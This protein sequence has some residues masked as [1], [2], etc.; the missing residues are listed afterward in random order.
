M[1]DL[2]FKKLLAFLFIASFLLSFCRP[3]ELVT[4]DILTGSDFSRTGEIKK[5]GLTYRFQQK[6]HEHVKDLFNYIYFQG[7]TL[8]FSLS[9]NRE[10]GKEH[11]KAWFVNSISGEQYKAERLEV[12]GKKIFGFSLLG[13]ILEQFFK[14]EL[15]KPVP[16][17]SYCCKDIPFGIIVEINDR[18]RIIQKEIKNSFV[19][20]YK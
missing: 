13:S 16:G 6:K 14:K 17:G 8:C 11:V 20:T 1:Q 2:N 7:D 18:G 5:T 12:E 4:E 9:L 19:I 10:I 3:T 15:T